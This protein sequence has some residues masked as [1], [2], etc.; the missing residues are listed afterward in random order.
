MLVKTLKTNKPSAFISF[1]V[2]S[3]CLFILDFI[4]SPSLQLESNHPI[5]SSVALFFN[6]NTW[7]SYTL[8][9]VIGLLIAMG[10]NNL[11][12]DRGVFKN[13]TI[14]PAFILV[15]MS[16][17]FDISA[18]WVSY[19]IMLFVLNK[20]M[21]IYQ[22]SK[23]YASLFDSGF[24]I[25]LST[26]IYPLS[27]LFFLLILV[28]V[29]IYST[30]NWR[31]FLIPLL[32]LLTPFLFAFTY[33]YYFDELSLLSQYFFNAFSFALPLFEWSVGLVIW[34][35]VLGIIF[36]L[37][38]KEM[39]DW[40]AMKNLRSR[41]AFYL[42]FAYSV[43]VFISLFFSAF[44]W[45]H[46]LLFGLPMSVLIANYFMF[47]HKKWWYEGSFIVLILSTIYLHLEPLF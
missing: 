42:F 6:T 34:S 29:F 16:S 18:I 24:L 43:C 3:L 47:L 32:G 23:P 37:S 12:T 14:L 2:L 36:L 46:L 33:G 4:A 8:V 5:F 26:I 41:K 17:V 39:V 10:W 13:I 1:F 22:K 25:G 21:S 31:Y 9:F 44:D 30:I 15:L 28:A 40:L 27:I 45:N 7:L 38:F 35:S 11:L 20:L 19:F